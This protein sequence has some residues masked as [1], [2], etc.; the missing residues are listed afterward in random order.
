MQF[1]KTVVIN[2]GVANYGSIMNMLRK[3]GADAILSDDPQEIAAARRLI[4]PGVGAFDSVANALWSRV[5][6][7]DVLEAQVL[8]KKVP[9]MGICVGMQLL[10]SRSEEGSS[11]GLGWLPGVV[12]R[13]DKRVNLPVPHMGWNV[14]VP[15]KETPIFGA[16]DEYK[17]YFVHSYRACDVLPEHILATTC[18][19]GEFVSAVN[20]D[21]I[22]GFQFHPEKSHKFGF[23]LFKK[24]V[25]A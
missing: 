12:K 9:F 21:N 25:E 8:E 2:L 11:V 15:K 3:V 4:L 14:V 22:Y 18:Y 19:G 6:L 20:F 23:G 10:F 7:K 5:D 24:F 13:F 17:F 16:G 1:G